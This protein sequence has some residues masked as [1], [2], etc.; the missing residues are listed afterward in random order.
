MDAADLKRLCTFYLPVNIQS[1]MFV[2][3][4]DIC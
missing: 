1:I 4:F 2:Y 3:L